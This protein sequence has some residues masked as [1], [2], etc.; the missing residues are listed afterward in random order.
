MC[1]VVMLKNFEVVEE[2][3]NC[4]RQCW[5][6][7]IGVVV[8]CGDKKECRKFVEKLQNHG[9]WALGDRDDRPEG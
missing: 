1:G 6:V 5:W 8:G 3:Q 4:R 2:L 7:F 9:G